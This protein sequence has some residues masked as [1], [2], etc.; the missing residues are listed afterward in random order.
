MGSHKSGKKELS[1]TEIEN[2]I[3]TTE[4]LFNVDLD[5]DTIR[6]KIQKYGCTESGIMRFIDNV[7]KDDPD[8][9]TIK[10]E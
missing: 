3:K 5:D 4:G 7:F 10:L 1:E 8:F 9:S 6:K 2:I